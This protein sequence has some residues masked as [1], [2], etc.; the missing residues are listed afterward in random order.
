MSELNEEYVD[1]FTNPL[2]QNEL[3]ESSLD[4]AAYSGFAPA[5][6]GTELTEEQ[7][8]RTYIY[9]GQRNDLS[10]GSSVSPWNNVRAERLT[11]QEIVDRF[12]NNYEINEAFGSVENFVNYL[13]EFTDLVE[14]NP[15]LQFWNAEAD[16]PQALINQATEDYSDGG[17]LRQSAQ[18]SVE[19]LKDEAREDAFNKLY[20]NPEYSSLL[21]EYG[22]PVSLQNKDGDGRVFIGGGYNETSEVDDQMSAG[23]YLKTAAAVGAGFLVGPAIASALA[24]ALGA[25]GAAAAA[26]GI[27]NSAT[28]LALTGGLDMEQALLSAATAGVGQELTSALQQSGALDAVGAAENA[29][30]LQSIVDGLVLRSGIDPTRPSLNQFDFP[31]NYTPPNERQSE[32][33]LKQEEINNFIR[34]YDDWNDL[35]KWERDAAL[36]EAGFPEQYGTGGQDPFE[37]IVIEPPVLPE[38]EE[39][40]PTFEE[41]VDAVKDVFPTWED[42]WGSLQD[43]LPKDPKEWGGVIRSVIEAAGVDLPDGNV[44]DI[45]NGGYGVIYDPTTGGTPGSFPGSILDPS[46]NSVFIPGLPV[47]LPPSSIIIGTIEDLVDD[48]IG[49][50]TEKA[51]DI[52]EGVVE[53]PSDLIGG[54]L[55][56]TTEVPQELWEIIIGGGS[57]AYEVLEDLLGETDAELMPEKQPVVPPVGGRDEDQEEAQKEQ[58][59]DSRREQEKLKEEEFSDVAEDTIAKEE[60][61]LGGVF[62]QDNGLTLGGYVNFDDTEYAPYGPQDD[63]DFVEDVVTEQT[64]EDPLSGAENETTP[65]ED[66]LSQGG[67]TL[68][69]YVDFGDPEYAPYGPEDPLST[70]E[71]ESP[72]S[73]ESPLSGSGG[74]GGG[75]LGGGAGDFTPFMAGIS[76]EVPGI[77]PLIQNPKVDYNAQLNALINRNVGLFE[78]II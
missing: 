53:N 39:A 77:A 10:G 24:P 59:E 73:T 30:D 15:E 49:T 4:T 47:G 17:S 54:I 20:S 36:L 55:S 37:D 27:V 3:M 40:L 43:K 45:L 44:Q 56:G 23:D 68:G 13:G 6:V 76:Y 62:Q 41:T 51:Q 34:G 22:I 7:L 42:L 18:A 16:I 14:A 67:L 31:D 32:E 65:T 19:R 74:S 35:E 64:P 60:E 75:M 26:G 33:D 28:Q 38:P 63:D 25:T 9:T 78:G 72:L 1:L 66:P 46:K 11:G 8:N 48:P 5:G 2:M 21:S 71:N 70:A 50:I 57:V 61:V 52:F 58:Y 29:S 12:E 69:G